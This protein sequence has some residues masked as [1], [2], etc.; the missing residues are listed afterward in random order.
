M[1]PELQTERLALREMR[2]EDAPALSAFQ[3]CEEYWRHQAVEPQEMAD[4]AGRIANYVKYRGPDDQRRLFVYVAMLKQNGMTIGTAS[5]QRFEHPAI[6]SLGI[7]IAASHGSKGYGTELARSLLAFGFAHVGLHRIAAD[8]A[9]ENR[10]CIRILEKIGMAREGVA[11]DCIWAQG[12]WWTE[13]KY[14]MLR[15]D[16]SSRNTASTSAACARNPTVNAAVRTHGK[17]SAYT[18][19][20]ASRAQK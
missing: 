9:V 2:A 14:A 8:V 10:A 19:A 11:R 12:R 1:L 20:C 4:S 18:M 3:G 6:A 7:G 15:S 17:P 13:V 16:Y 5:L